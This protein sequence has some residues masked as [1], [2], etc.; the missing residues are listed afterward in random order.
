MATLASAT[1][2]LARLIGEVVDST[3]TDD[4]AA[5]KTSLIDT[6]FPK[7][8]SAGDLPANDYYNYGTIWFLDCTSTGIEAS[9]LSS[10]TSYHLPARSPSLHRLP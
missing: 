6:N 10:P 4:G 8:D 3:A 2:D 5:G 7:R 9:L 1:L